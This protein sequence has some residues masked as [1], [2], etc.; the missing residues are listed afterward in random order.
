MKKAALYFI[1]EFD[2]DYYFTHN[3]KGEKRGIYIPQEGTKFQRLPK[4]G[5]LAFAPNEDIA[6]GSTVYFHHFAIDKR[7]KMDGKHY[8]AVEPH[9]IIAYEK[10]GEI[11]GYSRIVSK[12]IHTEK[13]LKN[14]ESIIKLPDVVPWESH[15]FEVLHNPTE[16]PV[17]KGE[18][19]W[20]YTNTDYI[21]EHLQEYSFLD[22]DKIVYN[23]T[24][25]EVLDPWVIV[26]TFDSKNRFNR[27]EEVVNGII[28]PKAATKTKNQV[29][30]VKGKKG[31]K[32][33]DEI[34]VSRTSSNVFPM[35]E[36][37]AVVNYRNIQLC[38]S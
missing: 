23:E 18:T 15:K 5:T 37:W 3:M 20:I 36:D 4:H 38:L 28:V 11:L 17:E 21:I 33:G 34:L 35:K 27:D 22:P 25:D 24:K 13:W 26:E 10:D 16:C 19:V 14:E 30:V 7:F 2:P 29:T 6:E 32:A 31:L 8:V 12:R 9:E 1:V